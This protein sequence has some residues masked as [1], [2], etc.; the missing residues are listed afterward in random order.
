MLAVPTF[1]LCPRQHVMSQQVVPAERRDRLEQ[2][3]LDGNAFL[4][5]RH[6]HPWYTDDRGCADQRGPKFCSLLDG[7]KSARVSLPN[8]APACWLTPAVGG[9]SSY[10]SA[11]P[12]AVVPSDV[13]P[14]MS[15]FPF[16]NNVAVVN[17]LATVMLLVAVNVPVLASYSFALARATTLFSPPAMSTL[18]LGSNVAV[19]ESLAWVMLPV[20]V[21][22]SA[23][24]SYSSALA[25]SPMP[26]DPPAI[27]TIPLDNN[28]AVYS[29]KFS[30]TILAV[31][32]K[33]PAAESYS[34]ATP[35]PL[36]STI[37]FDNN[38]AESASCAGDI[39]PVAVNIPTAASNISALSL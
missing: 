23:V 3:D 2:I 13:P 7:G 14:T 20:A 15:T 39:L 19:C 12:R 1:D 30:T 35:L 32:V 11:L 29:L 24:G 16:G 5:C 31:A 10:N 27:S 17:T 37:P 8:T 36:M 38:V 33:A 34:C 21:K 6:T 25:R 26:P 9:Y 28:V 22:I 18:P 4:G